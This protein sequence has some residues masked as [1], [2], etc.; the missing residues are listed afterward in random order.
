MCVCVW[1]RAVRIHLS[2]HFTEH[3]MDESIWRLA[4][5][6]MYVLCE[7]VCVCVMQTKLHKHIHVLQLLR[8]IIMH[9]LLC[10][11][12]IA[13]IIDF[14]HI[15]LHIS[16]SYRC[17]HICGAASIMLHPVMGQLCSHKWRL[18]PHLPLQSCHY[19]ECVLACTCVSSSLHKLTVCLAIISFN[20]HHRRVPR[21]NSV[22]SCCSG[23]SAA[24][25]QVT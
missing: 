17:L 19:I 15:H 7:C 6:Q 3:Q 2:S 12:H 16:Y 4:G 25:L 11:Y 8:V 24:Q 9:T 13:R 22:K 1:P 14:A 23:S 5:K 21:W 20:P 10:T 18:P